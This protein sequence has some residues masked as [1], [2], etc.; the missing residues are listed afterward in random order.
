MNHYTFA[1]ALLVASAS[2]CLASEMLSVWRNDI[3]QQ[4]LARRPHI[5]ARYTDATRSALEIPAEKY[6]LVIDLKSGGG[7]KAGCLELRAPKG[8]AQVLGP[9]GIHLQMVDAEGKSYS[10]LNSKEA[11]RVNIYRRGPYYIETH[12]LD[13]Q[14]SDEAGNAAPIKGEVVFYSYPEKFHI[15]AILHV[16]GQLKV[17]RAAVVVDTRAQTCASPAE[18]K[19][20]GGVRINDF[21]LLSGGES[22][23][24]CALV[25]PVPGGVDDVV[26]ERTQTGVRVSNY[27]YSHEAHSGATAD[28]NEG[29]KLSASFEIFPAESSDVTDDFRAEIQPLL[30]TSMTAKS[31]RTLGYDPVRGCYKVQT[32]T[33]GGFTHH[34]EHPNDYE[35]ASFSVRNDPVP[36]KIY[37]MHETRH[38]PGTVEC[39]VVLDETGRTLPV[40]VQISKNFAGEKE[41]PFYNPADT[42]FSETFFP[43][44]LEPEETCTLTS[45]HLYQNWGSHPLKQFSSLGAWMDYYHMS[46]GV[47]ETTCY[48]PFLFGGLDGVSIADLRP[49]SQRMWES[50]PQ[51]DNVAGHSFLRYREQDGRWHFLE[52]TGTT[53]RST[54]P[55]WADMSMS[56]LSDDGKAKVTLDVF[57][58]P[59]TDELR[60]FIHMRV[61]FLDDI[62]VYDGDFARNVRLLNIATWVQRLRYTTVAYGGPSG[63]AQVH[64]IKLNDDFTLAGV[65]LPSENGFATIYPDKHGANA[66]IVRSFDGQ[67]GGQAVTPGVSVIGQKDADTILML[68]P[69]PAPSPSHVDG[70]DTSSSLS[71]GERAGVRGIKAGDWLEIDL[72][73]MPYGGGTQDW[74]PAQ[75]AAFD[76]GLNAPKVTSVSAG[77]KI[78]DFPTR[79]A[80]DE[81]GVAEFSVTGGMNCIPLIVEG[82]KDYICQRIYLMDG[83]EKKL[84]DHAQK[85]ERDGYQVFA[86][87]DGTFGWVFLVMADGNEHRYRVE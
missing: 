59:Q 75:K 44:Y 64:T 42:P 12:W 17:K 54:G 33:A 14:L 49:M 34:Y 82:A 53:F 31:G 46:T 20:D 5:E 47:T 30:S 48:V 85:G 19:M 84:I 62:P 18:C 38:H 51:H 6:R 63:D 78:S 65:Q 4:P 10:S 24:S 16:T 57:E 87:D 39:G 21:V 55:N 79:I 7:Q 23:P 36:R 81:N 25:Y 71:P 1:A 40:T 66:F 70:T 8:A 3:A 61:D 72:F 9:D 74:Q 35:V 73:I 83:G 76:F 56:Y 27:I 29:D 28:W 60:N 58:L 2:T 86:K 13:V 22:Q 52:Y 69:V 15:G 43:L 50:Q 67:I 11:S 68:V 37:V 26:M 77:T 32:D 45:L 41:E 80:L